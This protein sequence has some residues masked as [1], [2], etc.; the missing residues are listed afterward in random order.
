[1]AA[2]HGI[3]KYTRCVHASCVSVATLSDLTTDGSALVL[4][5]GAAEDREG[6]QQELGK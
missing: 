3:S 5:A 1:M 4:T 6:S 2:E